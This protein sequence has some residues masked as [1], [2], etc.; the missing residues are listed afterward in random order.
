MIAKKPESDELS[1][2]SGF[3]WRTVLAIV[4]AAIVLLPAHLWLQLSSGIMLDLGLR[5][6]TLLLFVEV[7]RMWGK[8]LTKQEVFII[9]AMT[10]QIA[11]EVGL[12][13][14]IGIA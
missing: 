9:W 10:S 6:A 2:Q 8:K 14:P 3:T 11:W 1:L 13:F 4:Y 12:G 5:Y 7:S